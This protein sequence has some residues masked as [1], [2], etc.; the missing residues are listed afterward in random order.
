MRLWRTLRRWGASA[1]LFSA[2]CHGEALIATSDSRSCVSRTRCSGHCVQADPRQPARRSSEPAMIAQEANVSTGVIVGHRFRITTRTPTMLVLEFALGSV[3]IAALA[4]S[5][6]QLDRAR[7]TADALSLPGYKVD[8][9]DFSAYLSASSTCSG[10]ASLVIFRNGKAPRTA[11]ARSS[12][13]TLTGLLAYAV[14]GM[15]AL[16]TGEWR[17]STAECMA[18]IA[19]TLGDFLGE[20][21]ATDVTLS[22][23]ERRRFRPE[24]RRC[25]PSSALTV[26]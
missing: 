25:R 24:P 16:D 6:A 8:A 1:R 2:G 26:G 5:L 15:S 18:S 14:V 3:G 20:L 7:V 11:P 19:G 17:A 10:T 22:T 12:P 23:C 9:A 21:W 4:P 13:A